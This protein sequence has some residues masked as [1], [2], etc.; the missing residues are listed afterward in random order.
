MATSQHTAEV[1]VKGSTEGAT[2]PLKTLADE[3]GKTKKAIDAVGDSGAKFGERLDAIEGAMGKFNGTIGK[4]TSILG[5]A[6]LVGAVMGAVG[7]LGEMADRA[8][9]MEA[10]NQALKI[11]ISGAREATMGL[12]SD[13][14]LTLAA[15]KAVQLGIVKTDA[16]FA[17]LAGTAA[18]LG[19]ALGQDAAKS[20]EDLTVGL[21]RQSFEI[22]DNLGIMVKAEE[23][24]GAY[25][26]RIGK[27]ADALS[28]AE[29]KQAFLTIAMEKAEVAA[30]KSG[31]ELDTHASRVLRVKTSWNN[32]TDGLERATIGALGATLQGMDALVAGVSDLGMAAEDARIAYENMVDE[33]NSTR[34]EGKLGELLDQGVLYAQ[35]LGQ[36]AS[37][38]IE[39]AKAAEE[40]FQKEQKLYAETLIGP[41]LPPGGI[42]KGGGRA[43][44]QVAASPTDRSI[45]FDAGVGI[46]EDMD[47]AERQ[48]EYNLAFAEEL[49][50]REDRIAML[51]HEAELAQMQLDAGLIEADQVE[52]L[53]RRK[54][55]AEVELL[56]FQIA[57]AQTREEILDL[58]TEKRRKA[59]A[60]QMQVMSRA[61]AQ[62][63]K[64][65]QVKQARYEQVGTAV[66]DSLGKVAQAA[67]KAAEGEEYAVRKALAAIATGIRDQM[68]LTALKEFALAI[69]SAASF[70]YPGAAQHAAAGGLATAAA[71]VAGGMGAAINSTIPAEPSIDASASPDSPDMG[72]STPSG[73]SK[74]KGAGEGGDDDGV[75]TS[76]YDADLW[77]KRP[78][79]GGRKGG[80]SKGSVTINATV[81]GAD[82]EQVGIALQKL[83]RDAE[84]SNPKAIR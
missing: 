71:V 80:E 76:Y 13:Y 16:E 18:K 41:A 51:E 73:K 3:A 70:N 79:R 78:D 7:A 59:T 66:G 68:I 22:L 11:S 42:K 28:D 27:T 50:L 81:L 36:Q 44:P 33:V 25:A 23:A 48:Q 84:K 30:N 26:A 43:K 35:V 4:V 6:G 55:E 61:Q 56:D 53:A 74:G 15:N 31:V 12:V 64:A 45:S 49:A 60:A 37:A 2:K 75:P 29:K 5:G 83:I 82:K 32:F 58:E 52:E 21:G 14:Q 20:V 39:A 57:A 24:Y 47:R 72:S 69:A 67:I 9:Q 40:Q 46:A 65:L 17:K 54:Y 62:E 19:M 38:H 77:T 1:I 34:A 8:A 63:I 10:A